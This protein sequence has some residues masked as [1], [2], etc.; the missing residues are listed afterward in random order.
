MMCWPPGGTATFH[1]V[2]VLR[3]GVD[4]R[5]VDVVQPNLVARVAEAD[6][7]VHAVGQ[8]R[9]AVH[10]GAHRVGRSRAPSSAH[11]FAVPS[12]EP[13]LTKRAAPGSTATAWIRSW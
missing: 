4:E 5:P 6:H 13:P 3:E 11:S 1:R 12:C 7:K 8:R 9:D 2:G 10:G